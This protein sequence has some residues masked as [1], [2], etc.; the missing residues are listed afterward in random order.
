MINKVIFFLLSV[1]VVASCN[2]SAPE[3]EEVLEVNTEEEV[4]VSNDF[5]SRVE[6]A[7]EK[8]S[9][10]A[11]DVIQFDFHLIFRG[12][13][14]IKGS[15][16]LSTNS[17]QGILDKGNDEKIIFEGDKVFYSPAIFKS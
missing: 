8:E 11:H 6:R 9:F 10:L 7:H 16:T 17:Y 3:N 15:M 2:S 1:F 4:V 13:D 12:E 5:P 14:R